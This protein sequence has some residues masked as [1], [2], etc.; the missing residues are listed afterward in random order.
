[1]IMTTTKS[2]ALIAGLAFAFLVSSA[3][4]EESAYRRSL[5]ESAM[6]EGFGRSE[7]E[8]LSI[9]ATSNR[10]KTAERLREQASSG[11]FGK[12]LTFTFDK[13][14][15]EDDKTLSFVAEEGYLQIYADGSRFRLR[16]N[17]AKA[18][19]VKA[20]GGK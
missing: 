20:D 18:K 17:I 8:K 6:K 13:P 16:G 5:T 15:Q 14:T 11:A 9:A 1:M 2:S 3:I 10:S 12:L 19:P 7:V 4:A